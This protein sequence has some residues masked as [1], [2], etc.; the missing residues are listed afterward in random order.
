MIHIVVKEG[1]GFGRGGWNSG[2]Y[3]SVI[4]EGRV[5]KK[6]NSTD[7]TQLKT[8]RYAFDLAGIEYKEHSIL[9]SGVSERKAAAL[10]KELCE[11][12]KVQ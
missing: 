9:Y 11:K 2:Y 1:L 10:I 5:S 12:T 3:I 4:T 8:L 7:K 6:I